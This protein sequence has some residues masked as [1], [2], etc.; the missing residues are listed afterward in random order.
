[1]APVFEGVEQA[2]PEADP[3]AGGP[4]GRLV[5]M[6]NSV[7]VALSSVAHAD[8]L[9][10]GFPTAAPVAPIFIAYEKGYYKAE[11]LDVELSASPGV[12]GLQPVS[13]TSSGTLSS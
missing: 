6:V 12:N 4:V 9:K 7:I 1:M 3:G 2:P 10:V 8:K 13:S 5:A 11:G